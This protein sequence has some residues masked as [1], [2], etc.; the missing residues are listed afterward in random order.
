MHQATPI[1][2]MLQAATYDQNVRIG[3]LSFFEAITARQ[4]SP[5]S[6]IT[7]LGGLA[8]I[9]DAFEQALDFTNDS[10][11]R[12]VWG[13]NLHKQPLLQQDIAAFA[14]VQVPHIPA[15]ELGTEVLVEHL[16][17]RA[18]NEPRS[19]LGSAYA[20]AT[21]YMGGA[22]LCE[23]V[24]YA[25]QLSGASGVSY[26]ASFDTWGQSYWYQ[27][28]ERLNAIPLEPE[29]QQQVVMAAREA[30]DGIEQLIDV[31]HPLNESPTG[32]LVI[33]LNAQA[34][35]HAITGDMVEIKAMMRAH[36]R[37][38]RQFPYWEYRYGMRGRKFSWSDGAWLVALTSEA[39]VSINHQV[40]WLTR[41]MSTRGMPQWLM[42]CYLQVLYEEL[43]RA[44]PAK[45]ETYATLVEAA[46]MLAD[47]R[48]ASI[49]DA[50][51]VALDNTFYE[52]VGPEWRTWMP[53][54][55]GILASA[56]ADEHAG[57][58]HAVAGIEGWMT[59][60]ARF[61]EGWIAA[62]RDVIG[63]ARLSMA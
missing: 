6:Y 36:Q 1:T 45:R 57:I 61:P 54:C 50:T 30:L 12:E 25:M 37:S 14:Q 23:Q 19:L 16:R 24:T 4:L 52:Q 7:L 5:V 17:L 59:D 13:R 22:T 62:V 27:F 8:T 63:R 32:E 11:L 35:N 56:V 48:R 41:L 10:A 43:V 15:A 9:S 20:F 34:G 28:A 39:Q 49:S 44:I 18:S 40:R 33:L 29:Q 60:P 42:E 53:N 51:L 55:G 58:A 47:E 21:W 38:V 3:E 26:L 2:E 46:R 31:L